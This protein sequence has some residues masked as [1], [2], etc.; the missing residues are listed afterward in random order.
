VTTAQSS[1]AGQVG[2]VEAAMSDLFRLAASRR[3]H[4]ARQERCGI[5]LSRTGGSSYAASTTSA[6]SGCR[7]WPS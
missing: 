5:R 1:L 2:A 4:D 3:L 7:S 6:P